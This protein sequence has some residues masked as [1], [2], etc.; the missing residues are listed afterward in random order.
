MDV[1]CSEDTIKNLIFVVRGQFSTEEL[2]K[3]VEKRNRL[4]V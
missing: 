4:K 3:E 2:V 1:D